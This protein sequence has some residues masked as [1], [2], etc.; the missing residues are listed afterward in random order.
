MIKRKSAPAIRPVFWP[1]PKKLGNPF[2]GGW[3]GM[4][5]A[6]LGPLRGH[7]WSRM[8]SRLAPGPDRVISIRFP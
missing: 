3:N 5:F 8:A 2:R 4:R 6:V 7:G 1:E